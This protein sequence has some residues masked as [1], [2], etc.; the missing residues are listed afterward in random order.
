M[1]FSEIWNENIKVSISQTLIFVYVTS[2][3]KYNTSLHVM[4]TCVRIEK[5]DI[6]T[7]LGSTC[8]RPVRTNLKEKDH[9][10]S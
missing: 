1:I 8:H 3:A 10:I 7:K 6:W 4:N 9:Q 5:C 2:F